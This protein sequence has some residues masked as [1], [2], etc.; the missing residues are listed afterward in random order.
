MELLL[1]P[2]ED[3]LKGPPIDECVERR[4]LLSG[5]GVNPP[6]DSSVEEARINCVKR[7]LRIQFLS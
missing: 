5:G 1:Q 7:Y 2:D 4:A 6:S 3:G